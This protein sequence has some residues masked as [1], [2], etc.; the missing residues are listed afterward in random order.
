[1]AAARVDG[2]EL[3]G[4]ENQAPSVAGSSSGAIFRTISMRQTSRMSQ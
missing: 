2:C 1:V 4:G 3:R